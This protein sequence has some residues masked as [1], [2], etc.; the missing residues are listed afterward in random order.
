[1]PEAS[2]PTPARGPSGMQ[3]IARAAA[4][5][6]ALEGQGAGLSLGQI[7][8]ATG[9]PRPTVQRIADALKAE[10][11]AAVDPVH[12]GLRLGPVL[13]RLGASVRS[14]LASFAR[15]GLE[16][17]AWSVRETVALTVL[18]DAKA[19]VLALIHAPGRDIVLSSQVG[20]A[21]S[22]H[23][24]AEGKALLAGLP[25][26]RL[27]QLLPDPLPRRTARTETRL[28]VLLAEIAEVARSGIARDQ[29]GT[30]D[31]ICALAAGIADL[32]G[33]RYAISVIVPAARFATAEPML[34]DALL[35]CR[36]AITAATGVAGTTA[37]QGNGLNGPL[38]AD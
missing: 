19:V 14:D 37:R 21:W 24:T 13:A 30:A 33:L 34:R 36:D 23:C 32:A 3:L 22:I 20:A 7:A 11:L 10:G 38:F 17:L 25:E 2:D 16:R 18:Q 1:M 26:A 35:G 5:L 4:I 28:P 29:E 9:L 8:K 6:R 27:R 15:P 31:G 12:G